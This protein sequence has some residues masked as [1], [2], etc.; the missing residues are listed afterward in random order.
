MKPTDKIISYYA[1]TV[2]RPFLEAIKDMYQVSV[3]C[4][5]VAVEF[6]N[7]SNIYTYIV[8]NYHCICRQNVYV[9][10]TLKMAGNIVKWNHNSRLYLVK[11]LQFGIRYSI[12]LWYL[13]IVTWEITEWP[14]GA[15]FW[16]RFSVCIWRIASTNQYF[17][18]I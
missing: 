18:L 14:V 7:K 10:P 9:I 2:K 4:I 3:L 17:G 12:S 5:G 11:S 6:I 15:I 1:F 8:Q 16:W 13:T